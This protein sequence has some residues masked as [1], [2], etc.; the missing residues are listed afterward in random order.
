M[1]TRVAITGG[2]SGLGLALVRQLHAQGA[3]VAFVARHRDQVAAVAREYPGTHGIVGDVSIKGDIY[4]MALQILGDLGG[5][6]VL[7]NNASDLG[8]TPLALLG[9]TECEDLE[10]ALATNV[11]GPFRLTKAL[12]GALAASAREGRGAV[13]LNI[14]SD[15]AVNAYPNWGAYGASKAALRHLTSIW[16]AELSEEGVHFLSVDP[17]DMDTPL[18]ALAVPDADRS[19]LKRPQDAAQELLDAIANAMAIREVSDTQVASVARP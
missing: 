12:L 13:V 5:L 18:H 7:V 3:R 2:T 9:D 15:A 16:D 4:P 11:L 8:S 1:H 19:S 6:D 17:G 14:S 10:R